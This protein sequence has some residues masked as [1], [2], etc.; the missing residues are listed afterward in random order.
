MKGQTA[1]RLT[2]ALD[3]KFVPQCAVQRIYRE[4]L[5]TVFS[6]AHECRCRRERLNGDLL[7]PSQ[8]VAQATTELPRTS[9]TAGSVHYGT[10]VRCT[11]RYE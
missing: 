11:G 1:T 10:G 2:T 9:Q 8:E 7:V 4:H 5:S 3:V 6:G